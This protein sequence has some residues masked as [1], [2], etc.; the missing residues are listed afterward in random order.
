[1]K[2]EGWEMQCEESLSDGGCLPAHW[3]CVSGG[4]GRGADGGEGG[5]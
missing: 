3:G 4:E 2:V 1:M 5:G